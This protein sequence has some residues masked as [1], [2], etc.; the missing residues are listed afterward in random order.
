[1]QIN[2]GNKDICMTYV[3]SLNYVQLYCISNYKC[4]HTKKKTFAWKYHLLTKILFFF[5]DLWILK[6]SIFLFHELNMTLLTLPPT[7]PLLQCSS[8]MLCSASLIDRPQ[9][10][11][12]DD[13]RNFF[14]FKICFIQT[15]FRYKQNIHVGY[16]SIEQNKLT[17]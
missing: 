13:L 5:K 10:F 16:K 4:P 14:L 12:T 17:R 3:L 8:G 15:K 6:T 11:S 2:N 1:M 9:S 7:A